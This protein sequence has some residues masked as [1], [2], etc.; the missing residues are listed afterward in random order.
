M[1][2]D[3]Y[4]VLTFS[5][6]FAILLFSQS[7]FTQAPE[8][9]SYQAVIRDSGSALVVSQSVGMQISILQGSA[10]GTAVYSET[11]TPATNA[12]GLISVEVGAGTAVSGV[13]DSVDWSAGPYFIQTET[14]PAGGTNYT[15]SGT[16]QLLS[17]PYALYAKTSGS[18]TAGPQ[19]NDGISAYQS[20]L[21][22]GN[23]G[24]EADFINSLTGPQGNPGTNFFS[25]MQG[26]TQNVGGS[27]VNTLL[28]VNVVFATPFTGTP[29]VIC[30][31]SAEVATIFDDSFNVT[32][33]QVT[34]TGFSMI[35][36][37]VD[38]STWG[39]NMNVHW[40]A[41]E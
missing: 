38:G 7:A 37:R 3:I 25:A 20:W 30:T 2:S 4:S 36:N 34:S 32:T 24:T 15:I 27:G 35:V 12:N 40:M 39:Q 9:M 19:G 13:F 18:S 28:I 14:D 5:V 11:Q 33:R 1:K 23:S 29:H 16:S 21:N 41:F 22:L 6:F 8:K 31:A 10:S 26:G 17:V